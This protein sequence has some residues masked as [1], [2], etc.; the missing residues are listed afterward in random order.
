M[1]GNKIKKQAKVQI[2]IQI[3]DLKLYLENNYK[4]LAIEAKKEAI[5]LVEAYYEKEYIKEKDYLKYKKQ[6]DEY[7]AQMKEYNHQQFYRT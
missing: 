5:T 7:T 4:D 1:F 2:E 6:L 3:N